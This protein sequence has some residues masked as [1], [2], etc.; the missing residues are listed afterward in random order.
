MSF[1]ILIL[2]SLNKENN[3]RDG[4]LEARS[5]LI[6]IDFSDSIRSFSLYLL[7]SLRSYIRTLERLFLTGIQMHA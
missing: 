4:G 7:L 6:N 5:S 1:S 3:M 2:K